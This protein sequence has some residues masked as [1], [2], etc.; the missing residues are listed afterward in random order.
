MPYNNPYAIDL[1]KKLN[2]DVS[3]LRSKVVEFV[4]RDVEAQ[5]R[6]DAPAK[7]SP[8]PPLPTP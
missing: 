8:R 6:D 2:Y 7:R 4:D 3:G 5:G 1:L